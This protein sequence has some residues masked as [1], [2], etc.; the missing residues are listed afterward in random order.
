MAP[1][2]VLMD[3]RMP[4]CD[5][6]RPP[7][8]SLPRGRRAGSSS[9]PRSTSTSMSTPGYA[10]ARAVFCSRTRSRPSCWQRSGPSPP[11]MRSSHRAS[12]AGCCPSTRIGCPP[13]ALLS[14]AERARI[15]AH[16]PRARGAARNR[17]G[18]SNAEIA[19]Q[20]G[21]LGGD[22][23]DPRR[24]DPLQARAARSR[25]DRRVRLRDGVDQAGSRLT[26][27]ALRLSAAGDL[28]APALGDRSVSQTLAPS[29]GRSHA[30]ASPPCACAI[31]R[32]IAN[33]SRPRR[34]RG[35][36]RHG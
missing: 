34:V 1:D 31:V 36:R 2:V 30:A 25:P 15:A 17:A 8:R 24:A 7:R 20:V 3:V 18:L 21:A 16:R 33:P 14:R 11:A 6:V 32:T 9:S 35:R 10:R 26:A 5:G 4:E 13:P 28:I 12:P 27:G 29:C 23:Q 19:E 22:G